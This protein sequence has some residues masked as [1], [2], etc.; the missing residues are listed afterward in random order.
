MGY[1]ALSLPYDNNKCLGLVQFV[2]MNFVGLGQ[3]R[4]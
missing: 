4:K 2:K 1:Q 3:G